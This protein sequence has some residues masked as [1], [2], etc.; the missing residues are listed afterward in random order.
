M[1]I[2]ERPVPLEPG[3]GDYGEITGAGLEPKHIV[4]LRLLWGERRFLG[5]VTFFG[6]LLSTLI[7]LV[8]PPRYESTV[9]LMP[10]D[11][12]SGSGLAMAAIMA[13]K[14]NLGSMG[15]LGGS[16]AGAAGDLLGLKN[17]TALFTDMLGSRTV[18]DRMIQRFDLRKEY[19]NRYWEDA[20]KHLAKQTD[21]VVDRKSDVMSITVTDRDPRR[22]QQMAQA[23]VEELNG[24]V[25]EVSTSAAR[26]ERIF[27]EQRLQTV[28][29]DLDHISKEFSEY[30][31]K[32]TV[33]D[34]P[35]Q[36]KAM[37]EAAAQLQ[38]QLIAAQS[39]LEALEQ[40]YTPNN[41]RVR[42]V[43]ARVDE[44]KNQLSKMSGSAGTVDSSAGQDLGTGEL[45]PPIRELPLLGVR[46]LDLYRESRVQETVYELLTQ[47]YEL[48]KVQEAKEIPTVKVLDS[49]SLAERRSFPK[50]TL[51]VLLGTF[52]AMT[53]GIVVV[54]GSARWK[55]IDS[56]SPEKRF[57]M[58]GWTDLRDWL[59]TLTAIG[60]KPRALLI[61]LHPRGP[62]ETRR[63]EE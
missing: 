47:Q 16:L 10:P 8:L 43:K 56:N 39:E 57:L 38:G 24:L 21:I 48:A 29:Q 26:R 5:R 60:S 52:F 23:Y 41:V 2:I 30:E 62:G 42:S 61:R 55:E 1:P 31:S 18:E 34:M 13:A 37:V 4:W 36:A 51:I 32:N 35:Y 25:S 53:L 3:I 20:R 6:M 19:G 59:R 17:S 15:G 44:L 27:I 45:Y 33:L 58:E 54:L 40:I 14:N 63:E 12:Q 46:W 9:R 7:A 50:R 22:A 49:A 11:E 28:K